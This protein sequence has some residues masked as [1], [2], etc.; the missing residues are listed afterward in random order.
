MKS[1]K[2]LPPPCKRG[3]KVAVVAPSG[4][5]NPELLELGCE[6]LHSWGLEPV[7]RPQIFNRWSY[8]AGR[9]EDRL[10]W[11]LEAFRDPSVKG[12][13]AA[14]GGYGAMRLLPKIPWEKVKK[15]PKRFVGFSDITA[16]Q[17]AI[18]RKL[19]WICFSGPM[20][21][22]RLLFEGTEESRRGLKAA[23]MARELSEVLPQI[24]GTPLQRGKARGRLIGGNLSLVAASI[25][26]PYQPD[27]EGAILFLE[28]VGEPEYRIDRMFQQLKLAGVLDKIAGLA[29]GDFSNPE[30]NA[31]FFKEF[32]LP[33]LELPDNCPV[34]CDLPFGHI[35][36]NRTI[37]L[38]AEAEID[39][40]S[41]TLYIP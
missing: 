14:R 34:V 37:P 30:I 10:N 32:I 35:R 21:A 27:T 16:L 6:I 4:P 12:V 24:A 22:S 17:L 9:D 29:L 20:L 13:I 41:G 28:D 38:G 18:V 36:D 3:D 8:L 5:F 15:F 26:T 11:L 33:S 2:L 23:L 31:D 7:Y 25:G 1:K 40:E 19:G 39:G